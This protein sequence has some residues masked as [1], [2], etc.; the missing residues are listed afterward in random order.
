MQPSEQASILIVDD[1]PDKLLTL[2]A[3]LASDDVNIVKANSGRAALRCLLEQD[4]AAILLDVNMPGIDGFETARLIR[5]RKSSLYTPIIFITAFG[6]DMHMARG[7]SL[8]AVDYILAPVVPEVLKTKV[9]VFLDLA[10]RTNEVR[11]QARRLE[12]RARQLQMLTQASIAVSSSPNID[13]MVRVATDSARDILGAGHA[14]TLLVGEHHGLHPLS[15]LSERNGNGQSCRL[16]LPSADSQLHRFIQSLNKPLLVPPRDLSQHP[17]GRIV[18]ATIAEMPPSGCLVVPLTGR[19]GLN[20]GLIEVA[21]KQDGPFTDDDQAILVQLAQMTS[22]AIENVL[23]AEARE[24]N[25]IKDEFLATLS[26]E[27]RTPLTAILGW[28]QLLRTEALPQE[29]VANGLEI[30]ERNV[31]VQTKLIEDLLDVSRIITGKL[32]L[33]REPVDLVTV[34]QAAVDV[35]RPAAEARQVQIETAIHLAM[36]RIYGDPDR[37]Q[38]VLWNLLNNAIKF[39]PVGGRVVIRLEGLSGRV[40]IQVS[41]TGDGIAPEFLPYVFDRFRQADSTSTRSHSGLGIGL[42]IVRHV[43]ELHGG[44]V[45]AESA[46]RGQGAT[47]V[48]DLPIGTPT[49][50]LPGAPQSGGPAQAASAGAAAVD[51]AGVRVLVV[52]DEADARTVLGIVLRRYRAEVRLV[53]SAS[54]ALAAIEE[55]RPDVLLSDIGMPGQDGYE[56]IRQIRSRTASEGGQV[57][58]IALTAFA[59]SEDRARALAAG[60]QMHV[61]KPVVPHELLDIVARLVGRHGQSAPGHADGSVRTNLLAAS[62]AN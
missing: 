16:E 32:Q 5:Q 43:V 11:Q 47:F 25:R 30:I 9:A 10:R 26:H 57:P 44:S 60:F 56:L 15:V 19:D 27:L 58:A 46:G 40:Q 49:V 51:L 41:D 28:A 7:Y 55:F 3:V 54:E 17:I 59:R 62:P 18:S 37:L 33:K 14:A 50:S 42:A 12:Q 36:T 21:A 20:L 6:D 31:L 8:G 39:T 34:I 45:R 13:R 48:F 35:V 53:S 38:Q 23:F 29:E 4:F 52:D 61:S 24:A 22:V 1:R 2:E